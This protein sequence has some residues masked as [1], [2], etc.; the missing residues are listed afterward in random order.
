MSTDNIHPE[1]LSALAALGISLD[2]PTEYP[3][4]GDAFLLITP[5]PSGLF[6]VHHIESGVTNW[7][8]IMPAAAVVRYLA[9]KVGE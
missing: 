4:A 5:M 6:D 3:I 8:E 2:A 1:H 9:K 7:G